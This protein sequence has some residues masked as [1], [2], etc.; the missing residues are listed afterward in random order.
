MSKNGVQIKQCMKLQDLLWKTKLQV[1][2]EEQHHIFKN[3][4]QSKCTFAT[5]LYQLYTLKLTFINHKPTYFKSFINDHVI[6]MQLISFL[7]SEYI[8]RMKPDSKKGKVKERNGWW[9]R[10]KGSERVCFPS[11]STLPGNLGPHFRGLMGDGQW[12]TARVG[13]L[14]I[15]ERQLENLYRP[16]LN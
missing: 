16:A 8:L 3:S 10:E 14:L 9:W 6:L 12:W 15:W 1:H 13:Y 7:C 4:V 2:G 11:E 5:V